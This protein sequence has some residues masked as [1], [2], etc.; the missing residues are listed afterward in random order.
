M[1]KILLLIIAVI[2]LLSG[3][4]QSS[5][6]TSIPE[7]AEPEAPYVKEIMTSF[8]ANFILTSNGDVYSWGENEQGVLGL[9]EE[10]TAKVITPQKVV[11][12]EPIEK[13]VTSPLANTVFAISEGGNVYGWGA[14]LYK[15]ISDDEVS[16]FYTP[17]Q[18]HYDIGVS[19]IAL[20]HHIVTILSKNGDVYGYGWNQ[21]DDGIHDEG[22]SFLA[23]DHNLHKI[24]LPTG[25]EIAQFANSESSRV[26]L[27]SAGDVYIQGAFVQ[28]KMHYDNPT[29]ILF[30]EKITKIGAMTH[31][32]V[33]LSNTG[34]MYFVGEDRF[35]I[36][37]DDTA[38]YYD[39]YEAPILVSKVSD[40]ISDFSTSLSSIIIRTTDN[41]FFTW[42]YNLG[43][44]NAES[45]AE[46]IV[47]PNRLEIDDDSSVI[48]YHCGEFSSAYITEDHSVY[49]WGSNFQ[50]IF[51]DEA[52]ESSYRPKKLDFS[53]YL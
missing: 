45:N 13:L 19:E 49:V 50:N 47:T 20:S 4:F 44:N 15:T 2:I 26:F 52:H 31:G 6:D 33:G 27:T 32:V 43:K 36:V 42:G 29:Q 22:A 3:C 40:E 53:N 9:G 21:G 25:S 16:V 11:L 17:T 41:N 12:N 30:P 35:G 46:V 23:S 14:N 8:T 37:G 1:K 28:G 38:E 7:S 24:E 18:I 48:Y 5:H 51:M 34:K 39:I 10:L